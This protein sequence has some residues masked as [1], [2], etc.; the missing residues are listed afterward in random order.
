MNAVNGYNDNVKGRVTFVGCFVKNT[1]IAGLCL[2][3]F[4]P[5]CFKLGLAT[6]S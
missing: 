5:F 1:C 4:K 3:V 2:S 6:F